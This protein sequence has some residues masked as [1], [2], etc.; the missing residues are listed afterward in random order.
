LLSKQRKHISYRTCLVC[1]QKFEQ[2]ALL[3][4]SFVKGDINISKGAE[5]IGRG[6]Y[7]CFSKNCV[8]LLQKR[9]LE[10]SLRVGLNDW[11]WEKIVFELDNLVNEKR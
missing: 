1:R 4:I 10:N 9:F 2:C 8:K 5:K 7:V 11:D 6:S 3:R